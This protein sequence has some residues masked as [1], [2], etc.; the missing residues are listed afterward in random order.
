MDTKIFK[1][2]LKEIEELQETNNQN[3]KQNKITLE[4]Y[5]ETN[6]IIVGMYQALNRI[7]EL[8]NK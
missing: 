7:V 3:F 5:H 4:E 1:T 8:N 2:M 6:L